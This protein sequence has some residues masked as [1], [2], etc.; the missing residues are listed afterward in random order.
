MASIASRGGYSLAPTTDKYLTIGNEEYL[1]KLA[2]GNN[3]NSLRIGAMLAI[4]PDG[5]NN[6]TGC[7]LMI[8]VCSAN[9]TFANTAGYSAAST[10]NYIGADLYCPGNTGTPETATYQAGSGNPYFYCANGT[11]GVPTSI[12]RRVAT[13]DTFATIGGNAQRPI[14]AAGVGSTLR[15]TPIYVD[16]IKG[17]PNYTVNVWNCQQGNSATDF[18]HT[19]FLTGF[20]TSTPVLNGVTFTQITGSPGVIAC[21]ESAGNFDTVSLFWNRDSFPLEVYAI[22][23]RR[24][25]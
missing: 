21:S 12:R 9:A 2:I 16:I 10:T 8:G 24:L 14:A 23:V 22:G 17:S 15:R 13:T 11:Y 4:T 18:G 20:E 25:T 6:I 3:W 7:K 1:R 19:H 5:T